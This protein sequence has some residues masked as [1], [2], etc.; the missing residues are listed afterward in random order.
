MATEYVLLKMTDLRRILNEAR[1][2]GHNDKA[3]YISRNEF[4]ERTGKGRGKLQYDLKQ[5]PEIKGK[6]RSINWTAYCDLFP[7]FKKAS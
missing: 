4:M 3:E 6:G 1:E 7:Q 5:Y 2:D